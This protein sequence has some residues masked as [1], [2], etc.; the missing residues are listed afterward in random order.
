MVSMVGLLANHEPGCRS[1]GSIPHIELIYIMHIF[2]LQSSQPSLELVV[3]RA[4][5]KY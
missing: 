5:E 3:W 4:D 2:E 1:R